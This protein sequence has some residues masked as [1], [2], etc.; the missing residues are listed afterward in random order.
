M[1]ARD[2]LLDESSY[3]LIITSLSALLYDGGVLKLD[4][5]RLLTVPF[6]NLSAQTPR[7]TQVY[8]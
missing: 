8:C 4:S 5:S 7:K 6:Y 1:C 3:F 2:F